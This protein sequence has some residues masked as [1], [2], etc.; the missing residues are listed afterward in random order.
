MYQLNLR[1]AETLN[2]RRQD[3]LLAEPLKADDWCSYQW[4]L[5]SLSHRPGR[6][7][8]ICA[9]LFWKISCCL[10]NISSCRKQERE[11]AAR[12]GAWGEEMHNHGRIHG[13]NRKTKRRHAE[14]LQAF[15]LLGYY[16]QTNQTRGGR[17]WGGGR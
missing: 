4:F 15:G 13:I 9:H 5:I 3:S 17:G 10:T 8:A 14:Y 1:A 6:D 12:G 16:P 2:K 7:L 11:A